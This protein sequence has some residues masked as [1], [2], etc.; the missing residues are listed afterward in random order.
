MGI[1]GWQ[2]LKCMNNFQNEPEC[3]GY[4]AYVIGV[5]CKTDGV[6]QLCGNPKVLVMELPQPSGEQSKIILI[7]MHLLSYN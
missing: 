5:S 6:A 2:P 4:V 1:A 3:N 7:M